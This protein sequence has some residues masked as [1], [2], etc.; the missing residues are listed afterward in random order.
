LKTLK[1]FLRIIFVLHLIGKRYI[2][3]IEIFKTHYKSSTTN[4]E[5]NELVVLQFRSGVQTL[6]WAGGLNLSKFP[7]LKFGLLK[8]SR[9]LQD[10]QFIGSPAISFW[11]PN[12][13]LG[14]R[15]KLEQISQT[16][17]WTPKNITII[18]GLPNFVIAFPV[19]VQYK[20]TSTTGTHKGLPL[21][22]MYLTQTGNAIYQP[23]RFV[24]CTNLWD[25]INE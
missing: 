8:T 9:S 25:K 14:R 19:W 11:S 6:V 15:L 12:F 21:Q 2:I 7:K 10:Y 24:R 23:V 16:K 13:S 4:Q 20:K 17:V 5:I 3:K 22:E 1:V 18:A